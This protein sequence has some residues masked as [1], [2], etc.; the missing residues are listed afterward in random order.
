MVTTNKRE[1]IYNS[2]GVFVDT[3]PFEI[4]ECQKESSQ[5]EKP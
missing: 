1:L 2:E 4:N 5:N 3:A